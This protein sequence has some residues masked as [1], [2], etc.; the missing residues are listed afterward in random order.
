MEARKPA[1]YRHQQARNRQ[2]IGTSKPAGSIRKPA[3]TRP[4]DMMRS[5]KPARSKPARPD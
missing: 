1:R 2:T 3:K 4:L 5:L